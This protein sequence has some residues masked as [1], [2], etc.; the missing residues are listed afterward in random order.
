MVDSDTI[1]DTYV[2]TW[3]VCPSNAST[4]YIRLL[5]PIICSL[6]TLLY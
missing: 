1:Y 2:I 3:S 4:L 6:I 5:C